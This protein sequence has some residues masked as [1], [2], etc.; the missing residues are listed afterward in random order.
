[1]RLLFLSK[2][3]YMGKD[4]IDDRYGRFYELPEQLAARGHTVMG[5]CL[6]YHAR[7][8]GSA[9]RLETPNGV[10][11]LSR[12]LP[13]LFFDGIRQFHHDVQATIENLKPDIIIGC[14][15]AFQVVYADW[16]GKKYRIPV[17]VDLYD[18]F[19]AYGATHIPGLKAA[20]HRALKNAGGVTCISGPLR[21]WVVALREDETNTFTL[22]NAVDERLFKPLDQFQ[23]RENLGLPQEVKLIGTAGALTQSRGI[24]TLYRA[25]AQLVKHDPSI[26]LVL[27]GTKDIPPP[28][29]PNVHDLGQL[30]H[31]Q[32]PILLNA[33][34]IGIIC[35]KDSVFAQYCHPQKLLEM[36]ACHLPTIA[37]RVG[38]FA[39]DGTEPNT[40]T[41]PPENA[42]ELRRKILETLSKDRQKSGWSNVPTWASNAALL[43]D[44]L[45]Q[46]K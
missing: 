39:L 10:Q 14:S 18:Q 2:R 44:F 20:Y 15:D 3:Q 26:H 31:A 45:L 21:Q 13:P 33:L 4:L 42:G 5:R 11:W 25:H 27:A 34:D 37:T 32:I 38:I 23:C 1:M 29:H 36:Q 7:K 41:Y 9:D 43:E 6:A 8:P 30:D 24:E 46:I 35:N 22:G 12:D 19:E 16:L 40:E 17:M 28:T